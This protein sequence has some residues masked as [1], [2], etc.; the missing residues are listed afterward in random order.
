VDDEAAIR[1]TGRAVLQRLNFKSL[2]ATD[3]ADAMIQA[4][5]HRNELR[6]IISDLHMPN[7]DGLTFVRMVRQILPDIPIVMTSGQMD[8]ADAKEFKTLG[9]TNQ[10]GK[11]F[12]E[13]QLADVLKTIL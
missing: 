5:E 4:A 11:P 10:L 2:T 9:V 1:S 12:T 13:R 8:D 3:G 6:V 7:M